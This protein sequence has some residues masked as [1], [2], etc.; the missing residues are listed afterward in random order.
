M[1][2]WVL[3][4]VKNLLY[5]LDLFFNA[6]TAGDPRETMSSRMGKAKRDRNSRLAHFLCGF[7]HIDPFHCL[8][9]I[10]DDLGSRAL[11]QAI[12]PIIIVYIAGFL[13]LVVAGVIV[14]NFFW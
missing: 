7:L 6:F 5:A 13:L 10:N 14:Y 8:D 2:R 4:Y 12:W 9:A 11:T 1:H 3:R